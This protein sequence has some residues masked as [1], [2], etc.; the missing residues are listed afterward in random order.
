MCVLGDIVFQMKIKGMLVVSA[1]DIIGIT[2]TVV[3]EDGSMG[4]FVYSTSHPDEPEPEP[5]VVR[6]EMLVAGWKL[7]P[8]EGGSKTKVINFAIN[9]YRGN[10]PKFVLNAGAVTQ[11]EVFKKLIAQMDKSKED[12]SLPTSKDFY[13]MYGYNLKNGKKV[14]D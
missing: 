4:I 9:D 3:R 5:K 1:R 8:I 7:E 2:H 10:V 6:A 11:A 12:G 14:K 13:D